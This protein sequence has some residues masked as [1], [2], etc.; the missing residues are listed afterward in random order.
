MTRLSYSSARRALGGLTISLTVI[1][2]IG[3]GLWSRPTSVAAASVSKLLVIMEENHSLAQAEAGMPY[4]FGLAKTHG[5][6]TDYSAVSHPSV[7]NYL[8]IASGSTDGI[9]SD[10][11]PGSPAVHGQSVFDQAIA[12]G[13]TAKTYNESMKGKCSLN[14]TSGA[15]D[16][17]HNPWV[18][19]TDATEHANCL[20]HDV[21]LGGKLSGQLLN[22]VKAGTLPNAGMVT[23]NVNHDAHNG[24]LGAAD[25]W[26]KGWLPI[27][28]GGSDY[29]SGRLVLIVVFDE[30]CCTFPSDEVLAVDLSVSGKVVNTFLDHYSLARAYEDIT[31]TPFLNNAVTAPD[32]LSAFGTALPTRHRPQPR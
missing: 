30:G 17:I 8:G 5:Y 26:L 29:T 14:G 16:Y 28:M 1:G 27:I 7:P 9:T 6:A 18:Y 19:F 25:T 21:P 4:L 20:L 24:T 3:L 2:I 11:T 31:G 23:P 32:L 12:A 22:D 10:T 13:L 15:Y